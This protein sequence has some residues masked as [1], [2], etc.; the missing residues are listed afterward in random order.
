MKAPRSTTLLKLMHYGFAED[1]DESSETFCQL[2]GRIF[3]VIIIARLFSSAG[4]RAPQAVP[5]A[6]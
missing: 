2:H 1:I 6:L 4:S 5:L 3:C